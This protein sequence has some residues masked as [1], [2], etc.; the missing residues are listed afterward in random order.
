MSNQI[1]SEIRPGTYVGA[2]A[3]C[4]EQNQAWHAELSTE[5]A[6]WERNNGEAY[7]CGQVRS[8]PFYAGIWTKPDG[9]FNHASVSCHQVTDVD[10]SNPAKIVVTT[11][12]GEIVIDL[13]HDGA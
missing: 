5:V 2:A 7:F 3:R 9:S 8:S 11:A 4:V 6:R 12:S 10:L 13:F 1:K